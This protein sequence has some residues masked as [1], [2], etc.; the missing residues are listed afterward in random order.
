MTATYQ[1]P[2]IVDIRASENAGMCVTVA[3]H[4]WERFWRWITR[5]GPKQH[6][7]S[8]FQMNETWYRVEFNYPKGYYVI[9]PVQNEAKPSLGGEEGVLELVRAMAHEKYDADD[10]GWCAATGTPHY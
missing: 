9:V 10:A 2:E 8:A 5:Q 7:K 6:Y 4:G 1:E 3:V